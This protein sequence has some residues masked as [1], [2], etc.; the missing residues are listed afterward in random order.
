M[1]LLAKAPTFAPLV[2]R[3]GLSAV[4]LWFGINQILEP[5]AWTVW[6]PEWT[7]LLG[8]DATTVVYMNGGFEI[9]AG[10]MLLTGF[11][12]PFAALALFLHLCVIILE[13]GMTPTG[14]RDFGISVALLALAMFS[15]KPK[16]I[17]TSI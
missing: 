13:I 15:Y 9:I 16:N 6:V 10:L 2:L 7:A 3:L 8:I 5:Q 1:A 11:L 17:N 4:I 14:V 12:V